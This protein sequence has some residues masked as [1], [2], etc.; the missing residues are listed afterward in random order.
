MVIIT[1]TPYSHIRSHSIA[2]IPI[3]E[4]EENNGSYAFSAATMIGLVYSR[5]TY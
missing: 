5:G 1:H 3:A 2:R 4:E